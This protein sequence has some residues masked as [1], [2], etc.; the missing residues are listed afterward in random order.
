MI[1]GQ[2]ETEAEMSLGA[3]AEA[4]CREYPSI[5]PHL[6]QTIVKKT[7]S[8]LGTIGQGVSFPIWDRSKGRHLSS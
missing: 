8:D 6:A 1:Y 5:A 3:I 4:F 7:D 2:Q